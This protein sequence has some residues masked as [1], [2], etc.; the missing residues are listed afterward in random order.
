[1]LL[2]KLHDTDDPLLV[3]VCP[4][5]PYCNLL[6]S[7]HQQHSVTSL[8]TF[9]MPDARFDYIHINFVGP[10]LPF[11]GHLYILTCID[12]FTLCA[13]VSG[14]ISC[15]G[16]PSIIT[17]NCGCQFESTLW[18]Q[19][20]ELLGYSWIRTTAYH[21]FHCKQYRQMFSSTT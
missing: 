1:M 4:A 14:W 5:P 10:L 9:A 15:F 2:S 17:T 7:K 3:V 11:N 8:S 12:R 21:S 16:V 20:M 18:K 19:L 6:R 13:L